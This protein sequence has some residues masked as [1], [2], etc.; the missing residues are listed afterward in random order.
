MRIKMSTTM[1]NKIRVF[2]SYSHEDKKLVERL[3]GILEKE[4]IKNNLKF[5]KS[6]LIINIR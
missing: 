5:F 1:Q 6:L 3:A 2:I 4:S